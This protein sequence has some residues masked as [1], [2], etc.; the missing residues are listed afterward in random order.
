MTLQERENMLH[1]IQSEV[2]RRKEVER[3]PQPDVT[4]V[5]PK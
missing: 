3:L 5:E 2:T 1:F 4:D